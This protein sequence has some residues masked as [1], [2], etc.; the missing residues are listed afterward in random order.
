MRQDT[1]ASTDPTPFPRVSIVGVGCRATGTDFDHAWFGLD[2]LA[3]AGLTPRQRTT[4]EVAVEALDDSGLGCL[5]PGSQAAVVFGAIGGANSAHHLSRA[6]E[7]RGPSFTVDSQRAS[8]LVAVDMGVRLLADESVPFVVAGG[9]DLALLPDISDLWIPHSRAGA[10]DSAGSGVCTVVVLQRTADALRTRTRRYAEIGGPAIGFPDV[11][12]PDAHIALDGPGAAAGRERGEEPPILL[13][14]TAAD[15]ATLAALALRWAVALGSYRSLR[16][17]AAATARLVPEQTRAAVLAQ[18]RTEAAARLRTLAQRI[19]TP[20]AA[21]LHAPQLIATGPPPGALEIFDPAP[22]RHPGTVLLLFPGTG[23][24]SRMGRSLAARYPVFAG[25]LAAAADAV[26]AAGGP[27]VWTP[28]N[29][30]RPRPAPDSGWR[31]AEHGGT[32]HPTG[33]FATGAGTAPAEAPVVAPESEPSTAWTAGIGGDP[34][35]GEPHP[36]DRLGGD[37]GWGAAEFAHA[38]LFVFQVALAELLGSWGIRADAVAG[39]GTGEIAAAVVSGGLSLADAARVVVT[40]ARLI[41]R[42][43]TAGAA[44]VLEA[45]P[46]EVR[47]LVEPMRAEVAMAAVDGP[48]TITVSG[49]PRYV[50]AL[51]R[52]AHRRAI[53]AQRLPD[54][55]VP[56]PSHLPSIRARA[57]ELRDAL[58]DLAPGRPWCPLY[59]TTRRGLVLRAGSDSDSLL[60]ADYWAANVS[61]AVELS[62]ALEQAAAE[63]I[64]AVLEI[65]PAPALIPMVRRHS[66]FRDSAHPVLTPGDEARSLLHTIARLFSDGHPVDWTALGP[67]TAAPPQRQWRRDDSGA[68]RRWQPPVTD[69]VPA[70]FP[71]VEI[72]PEGAYVVTGGLGPRGEA[73]VR[74]LLTAGARD[75]VVLTRSPRP[76]P[77]GLAGMEDR[78]VLMRCDCADRTDLATAL[79]DI[80]ECGAAIRGVVHASGESRLTAAVDLLELTAADPTDFTVLLTATPAADEPG[81]VRELAAAQVNRRVICVEWEVGPAA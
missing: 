63:G 46:A 74:W 29:G 49:E 7:L 13:P 42:V 53:F 44:A 23:G 17:F 54:E 41:Q 51:V 24:H 71:A 75:V 60:D 33:I 78:I 14:I 76:L 73:A 10:P 6:L 39:H 56:Q 58:A 12:R 40:R 61:G 1:R 79:Q 4:L 81:A 62:A 32:C 18:D 55:S 38:A 11:G 50:E 43:G 77:L 65:G 5:A 69:R 52:R 30:F 16:E 45:T 35:T 9:V 19:A 27:R 2:R 20:G 34:G 3:A 26:A 36:T 57:A 28:R 47:R 68:D 72:R 21:R 67:H 37:S 48:T 31:S 8:P 15:S 22:T 80:R 70:A 64:S 59:S 66:P 25:M